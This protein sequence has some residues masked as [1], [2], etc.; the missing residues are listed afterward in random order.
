MVVHG[1]T[2]TSGV[3]CASVSLPLRDQL[4]SRG[5]VRPKPGRST[6]SLVMTPLMDGFSVDSRLSGWARLTVALYAWWEVT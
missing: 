6:G 2:W 4:R 3:A 1:R 5:Y